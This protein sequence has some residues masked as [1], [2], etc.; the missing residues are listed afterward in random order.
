MHVLVTGCGGFLG[1]E[2]CRQLVARG[3]RVR[4]LARSDYPA[5]RA[6]SVEL[7]R[8]DIQDRNAVMQA[9][10]GVDVVVHTAALAGVWGPYATYHGINVV[11]TEQ[12]IDACKQQQVGALVFTSSPSVTFDGRDQRGIDESAAYP[13]RWLCAYPQTKAIAEQKVL[14]ADHRGG[15]RTCALRPH[16]IWGEDDPHLLPRLV[17][18]ARQGRLRQV[19]PGSNRIDTIHVVN[20]AYAHLLAIDRLTESSGSLVDRAA[21]RAYFITQGEAVA[22]WDWINNLL[23]LAKAPLVT[24][25]IS[26]RAAYA[27]GAMLEA[28]YK[29][30]RRHEEP[31]MTRFVAAQLGRDHYFNISAAQDRLGYRPLVPTVAGLQQ[32]EAAWGNRDLTTISNGAAGRR[33]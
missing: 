7:V 28:V 21:G 31:P 4:G 9:C 14:Q 10:R 24:K 23:K 11:G 22:C 13:K 16:L 1:A 27:L 32:L 20:A 33:H 12:V 30:L 5:L 8:G 19:G 2:I 29:G 25:R 15:L 17:T 6:A 26:L 3:D 18:R